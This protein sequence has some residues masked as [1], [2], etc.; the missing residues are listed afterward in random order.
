MCMLD[1]YVSV[2]FCGLFQVSLAR[3]LPQEE[4]V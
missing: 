1:V 4:I 2:I 3:N